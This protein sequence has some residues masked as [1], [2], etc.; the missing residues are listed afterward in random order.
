MLSFALTCIVLYLSSRGEELG[1]AEN[2]G[3][4]AGL[5]HRVVNAGPNG[6]RLIGR[7]SDAGGRHFD[8]DSIIEAAKVD[9]ARR[10]AILVEIET[11]FASGNDRYLEL[12]DVVIG[13]AGGIGKDAHRA[14]GSGSKSFVVVK[15]EAK[16]ER[17]L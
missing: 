15:G 17:V 5:T 12:L 7:G 3:V 4:V 6:V 16:V 13:Q 11:Q 14:T 2:V 1:K 10:G 9:L 8:F